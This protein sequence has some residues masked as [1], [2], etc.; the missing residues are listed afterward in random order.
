M[1]FKKFM[2]QFRFTPEWA[3]HIALEQEGLVLRE[4]VIV[5]EAQLLIETVGS[6]YPTIDIGPELSAC[7]VEW[8]TSPLQIG[9]M[10]AAVYLAHS[11]IQDGARKVGLGV[12]FVPLAP[13]SMP[14]DVTDIPRYREIESRLD[15]ATL[16]AACRSVGIHFHV[17]MPDA[18]TALRIYNHVIGQTSRLIELGTVSA[19]GGRMGLYKTMGTDWNPPSFESWEALFSYAIQHGWVNDPRSWYALIRISKHGTIEFRMFDSTSDVDLIVRWA[20][21]CHRLCLEAMNRSF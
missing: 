16:R 8:R 13:E 5:P 2:D 19:D 17:G 14:L 12:Q 20:E 18:G 10:R 1:N 6:Q 9:D 15:E 7:Q 11:A 3:G 4:G 21:E